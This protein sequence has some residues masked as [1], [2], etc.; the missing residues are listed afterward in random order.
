MA[1]RMCRDCSYSACNNNNNN[2]RCEETEQIRANHRRFA[3][4]VPTK[5]SQKESKATESTLDAILDAPK[6]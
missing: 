5:V 1:D 4:F 6:V 2:N 3:T